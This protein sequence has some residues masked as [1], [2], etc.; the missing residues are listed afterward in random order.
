MAARQARVGRREFLGRGTKVAAWVGLGA[1]LGWPG[2]ARASV[3]LDVFVHPGVDAGTPNMDVLAAV[4]SGQ[5]KRWG[6][7]VPVKVFN[8]PAQSPERVEFDRVVL[9]KTPEQVAQHWVDR[10]VRGEGQPPTQV[11]RV[12]LMARVVA[13]LPG[14]IGYAPPDKVG[15]AK[16]RVA[17][18]IRD[19]KVVA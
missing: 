9:K 5:Q 17:A 3:S 6:N 11:P 14:A 10:L 8:L 19:G 4:F 18:R 16:I 7:G 12:D 15:A 13:V 2:R 1:A